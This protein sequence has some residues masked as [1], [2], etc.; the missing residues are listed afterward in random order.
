MTNV[1]KTG[2]K[3]ALTPVL[4]SKIRMHIKNGLT[5]RDTS[6]NLG[7]PEST[8][9]TWHSENYLNLREEV[10]LAELE[11]SLQQ[12]EA[13]S[14]KLMELSEL[15]DKGGVNTKLVSIKQ[16]EAEFLRSNLLI[17][18]RYY[19]KR[20]AQASGNVTINVVNFNKDKANEVL[21]LTEQLEVVE[22]EAK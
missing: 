7:I 5:L 9:Y 6:K 14:R 18:R 16:R 17:A 3:T 2:P 15:D 4:I 19:D 1:V 10:K 22:G 20:E 12:A 13:F 11:H 8:L 21:D